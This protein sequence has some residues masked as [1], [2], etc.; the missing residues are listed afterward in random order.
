MWLVICAQR[1]TG[2]PSQAPVSSGSIHLMW[3][4]CSLWETLLSSTW[5]YPLDYRGKGF[6][7]SLWSRAGKLSRFPAPP[8]RLK[9][10]IIVYRLSNRVS[11]KCA[12]ILLNSR[13]NKFRYLFV[14]LLG[15][16]SEQTQSQPGIF[17]CFFFVSTGYIFIF[18]TN[19]IIVCL[20]RNGSGS[21]SGVSRAIK[22]WTIA[23]Y[24]A[25]PAVPGGVDRSKGYCL[26][27]PPI[28]HPK[29]SLIFAKDLWDVKLEPFT[30]P[31]HPFVLLFIL[32]I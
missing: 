18:S 29:S 31:A 9:C 1:R 14:K 5:E 3:Q 11:R 24:L 20:R 16:L 25:T 30:P 28:R 32:D 10:D 7:L 21:G 26:S 17:F 19:A 12:A 23:A 6:S 8:K 4:H 2:A 22:Q 13:V 15:L 27:P